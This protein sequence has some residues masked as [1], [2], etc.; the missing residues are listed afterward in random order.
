MATNLQTYSKVSI[1]VNSFLLAEAV[2]VQVSRQTNSSQI[3]T[4]EKG[5]A[6]ESPGAAM[7]TISVKNAVPSSDFELDPGK[8][9]TDNKV[10]EFTVFAGGRT[11]VFKGFIISDNFSYAANSESSLSFEARGNYGEWT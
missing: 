1:Y 2:D 7:C 5:Y 11:L 8:F 4:I 10:V 9:M 6:G 3:I